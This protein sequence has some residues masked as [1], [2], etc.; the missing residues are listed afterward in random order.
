[1]ILTRVIAFIVYVK[2]L[3]FRFPAQSTKSALSLHTLK[4]V[5]RR[6]NA[7]FACLTQV[8][9]SFFL[10]SQAQIHQT[11]VVISLGGRESG[12]QK[13]FAAYTNDQS[14]FTKLDK[15]GIIK[16]GEKVKSGDILCA[17]LRPAKEDDSIISLFQ[18]PS[19]KKKKYL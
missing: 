5:I 10:I 18:D 14:V 11:A 19:K 7:Q 17:Y 16:E 4:H 15:D 1:M 2:I 3:D 6:Q 12:V 13:E 9:K 8:G